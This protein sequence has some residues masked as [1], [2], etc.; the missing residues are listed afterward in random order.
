M[1][2]RLLVLLAVALGAVAG[3]GENGDK[4]PGTSASLPPATPDSTAATAVYQGPEGFEVT[5]HFRDDHVWLLLPEGTV[6]LPHIPSASGAKYSDIHYS[7]TTGQ[8]EAHV[9]LW[10]KGDDAI[11]SRENRPELTLKNNRRLAVWEH[12]RL[13]G[14]DFRAVGQEP[15]WVLEIRGDGRIVYTGDY[16]QSRLE[17]A[18]P[19]PAESQDPPLTTYDCRSP[20]HRLVIA[21]SPDPCQDTMS[22]EEFASTVSLSLDGRNLQGC[23]RALH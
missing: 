12:A 10:T 8:G 18:R 21:I 9:M 16:G 5:A 2:R 22:G 20:G 15:G 11:L 1:K 3:C 13:T 7:D 4:A 23:G 6:K 19:E 14:V 17:F